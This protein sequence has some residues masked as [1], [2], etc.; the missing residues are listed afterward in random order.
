M[1]LQPAAEAG[2]HAPHSVL[3]TDSDKG[4]P[5]RC[6]RVPFP[7]LVPEDPSVFAAPSAGLS[8]ELAFAHPCLDTGTWICSSVSL[9]MELA[10]ILYE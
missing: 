1:C 4:P 3:R 2:G 7:L 9:G 5:R 6:G 8:V 10:Q